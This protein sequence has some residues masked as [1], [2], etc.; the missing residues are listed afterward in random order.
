MS[1]NRPN[2]YFIDAECTILCDNKPLKKF[3]K[4]KMENN[5]V[6]NWSVELSSCKLN[7]QYIKGIKSMLADWLLWLVEAKL[8]DCNYEAKGQDFGKTLSEELSLLLLQWHNHYKNLK[9]LPIPQSTPTG[10]CILQVH[11]YFITPA[12]NTK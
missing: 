5:K 1:L 9:W 12:C 8:R 3:L 11:M 10:K 6:K 2:F 4:G 7:I